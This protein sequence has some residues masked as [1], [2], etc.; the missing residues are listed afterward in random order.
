[1]RIRINELIIRDFRGFMGENRISFNDGIN[2][3]HGPVGS[4]KTSIVQSI[5]YALYGTQLEVKER[6]SKLTD[7]IN[8]EANSLLVKLVLT[9]G[10]EVI[11]ELKKSG[12]NVRESSSAIINGIRYKDDEVTSKIIET[13]GVDD[14]DFERF[15][16]VTHRTLEAL[17]YGSVTKRSLFIDK[18]FGL[19]IL[20]NLNRSLPMS[21]IE[22][23]INKLRQRLASVKELPEIIVK[24]GS[25]E[26]AQGKVNEL[27]EE[28]EKLR[29]EEE[30]LSNAYNN[31]LRKREELLK[32]FRGIEDIYSNYI[33]T[34]IRREN[35]EQ[36][37]EKAGIKE[38]N[39]TSI[40]LRLERLRDLLIEKLEEFALVKEADDVSKLV[41]TN[42]NLSE[43]TEKVYNA[44]EGLA[45]LKDKFIED[46]EY[47][48]NIRNDLEL[49]SESLKASLKELES[50]ISQEE[51]RV[52][53]YKALV[54]KYGEPVKIRR[55]VEE[56][57]RRLE[58]LSVE[59]GFRSSLLNVLQYILSNHE[60]RCPVCNKSLSEEDYENIKRRIEELSR[61]R[62]DEIEDMKN[63]LNELERVLTNMETL[64]PIV[65]DYE[66]TIERS[67][68]IR[69]RLETVLSKLETIE[70]SIRDIDRRIQTLTR[71]VDEFRAEVD[72]IDKEI[73]YLRRY[74]ELNSLRRQEEELRQQLS[75]LGIDTRAITGIED[76][77][78]YID[79]RLTQVRAKLSDDSA[80]LSRLELALSSIG[81]DKEDPSTLR[82]RLDFLEDFYN[83]LT[84]I[85]AGIRDVQ[86]RVRDEMIKI[87]RD[88]VGSIFEMLYPYDDLEGAGI[89]VT[90]KDKGIIGIVSEYTL[91]AFRPGGRKVT[92]SRLSDGQR[93]TIALSFL[94]SVYRATNHNI[95]F[96]LM[97]EPIPYVDENIRRAFASLL[98]RFISEGLI[99]QVIIT[100]Q[101][102][103]LVNDIV[104]AA[105]EANVRY[106]M[107]KLIKEENKRR[108]V[109]I[110]DYDM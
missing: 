96:L 33:A 70:K 30:E 53:E 46:K 102:E 78:R 68:D 86:A 49:Q 29:K 60:E 9:N 61:S 50:R 89:E 52:R 3:I 24:Y 37:L 45:R 10:I 56:F 36:E 11:R 20:D 55:D 13:L 41:I 80:E 91:Y 101:S 23:L 4:G 58:R 79:E 18:L 59:E 14:D 104:N 110:T 40:R 82:K 106:S 34:R 72:E 105:R 54:N 100:T 66:A 107:I 67:R 92:I 65:N 62:N 19:E 6:V 22:D 15:V 26:R 109:Q 25:I 17:V 48:S 57:R 32:G 93:L 28:I 95:D 71:F 74:R 8:E 43:V 42:D 12:E 21:Q 16:L 75:N 63:K 7:L 73:S 2:I 5:E 83:K 97:D 27:R 44:F 103:G 77:I 90:V 64:L 99:N 39:E 94:L 88:N 84:R 38:V 47:L 51:P 98:T 35:L 85:R 1:M 31:L 69:S 81:F 87:V 108:I 76:Q